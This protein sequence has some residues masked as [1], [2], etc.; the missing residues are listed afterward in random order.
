MNQ[1]EC[2]LT[3][4]AKQNFFI[5]TLET[6]SSDRLDFHDVAV[7][8]IKNALEAAFLAGAELGMRTPKP[9]EAEIAA[10]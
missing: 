7:W 4:I 9:T 6:R 10:D 3:L 2:I 5:D 8:Q 1:I